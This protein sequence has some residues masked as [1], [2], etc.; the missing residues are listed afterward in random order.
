MALQT[1]TK[2]R[3][4][5]PFIITTVAILVIL[6]GYTAYAATNDTWPFLTDHSSEILKPDTTTGSQNSNN[7]STDKNNETPDQAD[8]TPVQSSPPENGDSTPTDRLTG[9]INYKQVS[10]GNLVIRNTINQRVSS[11]NCTLTL[12]DSSNHTVTRSA[13]IVAN[14]SSSTC[15]GFSVPTSDLHGGAW[16]ITI[17]LTSGDKHG[18]IRSSVTI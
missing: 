1:R 12:T 5:K 4:R 11:G 18:T 15:E 17:H 14:P 10:G 9:V 16:S 8:K 13:D 3:S 2:K 6:G 7:K